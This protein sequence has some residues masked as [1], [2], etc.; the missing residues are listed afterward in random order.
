MDPYRKPQPLSTQQHSSR[1]RFLSAMKPDRQTLPRFL[2]NLRY[3]FLDSWFDVV[4]ILAIAGVAG[5]VWIIQ[6]HPPR[7]FPLFSPDGS[8]LAPE[9]AYP[10]REPIF[11]S[12]TAGLICALIPIGVILL[13]QLW[14]RSFADFSSAI[15]GLF[16]ALV[17]GTCFQVILKKSIGGLRPHFLAICNPVIPEG[18]V[19]EGF[20]GIMYSIEQVCTGDTS[21]INNALQSFPSGHSE[22]AFAGLGYLAIYLFTHLRI[23]DKTK[24]SRSGFWRMLIVVMPLL[25]ATY[26][27]CTL[28]LGYHHHAHDCFFGALIGAVCAVLGYRSVF[29]SLLDGRTNFRPRLGRRMKRAHEQERQFGDEEQG[30]ELSELGPVDGNETLRRGQRRVRSASRS[31]SGSDTENEEVHAS[32]V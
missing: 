12:L 30:R 24:E 22:I 10:Y 1:V 8:T 18:V 26:I 6:A 21:R 13:S 2:R 17:T 11:S 28:V 29:R 15:L 14:L 32:V 27:A 31:E 9:I 20:N 4:C 25:L 5:A 3:F 16:Y 23:G 7:L 19:G